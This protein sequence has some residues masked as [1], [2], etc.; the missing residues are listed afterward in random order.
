MP[1][2]IKI[3]LGFL[4]SILVFCFQMQFYVPFAWDKKRSGGYVFYRGGPFYPASD[5]WAWLF[6]LT[7]LLIPAYILVSPKILK[8][9]RRRRGLCVICG[10]DLRMSNKLCPECGT[11]ISRDP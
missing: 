7:L 5:L 2:F 11:P 3:I 9:R 6:F 10:Y 8:L 1:Q 4:P